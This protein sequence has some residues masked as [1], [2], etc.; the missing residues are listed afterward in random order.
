MELSSI[1][2]L[3]PARLEALRAVGIVSLRDLLMYLP[4][5]Y[6][7]LTE[8]APCALDMEGMF[9]FRGRILQ[10]PTLSFH[11]ALSRCECV[12]EDTSGRLRVV[13][14]NQPWM[15]KTLHQGDIVTLYGRLVRTKQ[16]RR[17]LQNPQRV[18][19]GEI[20]SQYRPIPG[21][22]GKTLRDMI[23]SVLPLADELL[24]ETLPPMILS[25][26]DLPGR[27]ESV[28]TAHAPPSLD[29]VRRAR[30]RLALEE[31]LMYMTA[32]HMQRD[33]KPEG[34]PMEIPE[35]TQT[36]FW[37]AQGFAPTASQKKVLSE[38]LSDLSRKTAMSRLVQGDVGCGKTA[39]AFG[40]IYAAVMAGY[41]CAMMAPTEILA[42]Q[43]FAQAQKVLG[44]LGITCGLLVGSLKASEKRN[45]HEQL[46]SGTW[47]AVFGTHALISEGVEY[48]NLGLVI[49]DEQHRFGVRQRSAL[50]DRGIAGQ[51]HPHVLVMSATPI[52][53]T[54]ALIL[55]G[56][57]DVSVVS[58]LP[59]GRK[60]VRT[61]LVP[62]EKRHDMYAFLRREVE[63][64]HQAYVVCPLVEDSERTAD[65]RSVQATYEDLTQTELKGLHVGLTWG[66]QKADEKEQTLSAFA[67]GE[68]Q[69]LISTT[70]IEVGVNVPNATVM[71]VENAERFGL[72][73]LH[74][75]RGRVGRGS[76]ESWCFLLADASQKLKIMTQTNDGFVIA[77][78]DL[79]I[80]GPGDL[81][82]TR[83]S[84]QE[85]LGF[86][87]DGDVR[88]LE[89]AKHCVDYIFGEKS[90]ASERE[91]LV[92][93][94]S[95]KYASLVGCMARN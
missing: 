20:R 58:E 35:E 1:R 5:A 31:M 42:R 81:L 84:G 78:K 37:K 77:Q 32:V 93:N 64:G 94:A 89:S 87:L 57:L 66:Q 73:Q 38:I 46:K 4:V 39:I 67:R 27:S 6:D 92:K 44:R 82:G 11:G 45:A 41:Q 40:A 7:D 85:S 12:L 48:Q 54:L 68:M 50:S 25:R 80:R 90:L 61:R 70:V 55:Y 43:H 83:Q 2:G 14:F 8:S 53:R 49:T 74:Q 29:A 65:I 52:P 88:L 47:Q 72:S 19:L 69:V 22:P 79:E 24:E 30:R 36:R 56:D 71:V 15:Q 60:P 26:Y 62:E 10:R 33:E 17:E 28:R 23:L 59:A 51:K 9:A 16:G 34:Y 63:K 18:T 76:K 95:E 3:G 86:L 21:I 13:W 91:V 75:L